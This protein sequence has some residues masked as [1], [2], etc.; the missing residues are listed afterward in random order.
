[1]LAGGA[2]VHVNPHKVTSLRS[3]RDRDAD[4]RYFTKKGRMQIRLNDGKYVTVTESC[5]TVRKQIEEAER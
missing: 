2:E 3:A 5:A 4:H 1:V